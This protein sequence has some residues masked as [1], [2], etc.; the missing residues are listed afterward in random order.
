M[1][2]SDG[3]SC[4]ATAT[5]ANGALAAARTAPIRF[6]AA[7][8]LGLSSDLWAPTSMTGTGR[9]WRAKLRAAAV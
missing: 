8:E 1:A 3:V 4:M 9:S 7:S 2:S 5:S 6:D